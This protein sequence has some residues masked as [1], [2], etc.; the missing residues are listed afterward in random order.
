MKYIA[1]V[2]DYLY[3]LILPFFGVLL[4]IYYQ[5][6][7][8]DKRRVWFVLFI[9]TILLLF[10]TAVFQIYSSIMIFIQDYVDRNVLG[11]QIPVPAFASLQCIFFI[12]F[13]P[14]VKWLLNLLLKNGCDLSLLSRIPIGLSIGALGFLCFGGGEYFA[15]TTGA[16]GLIWIVLG[17]VFLGLGE[18]FL[19][20]P[21]LTAIATFSPKRWAGTFMGIFSI[22]L[23]SSSFLAGQLAN[24]LAGKW[25]IRTVS[26]TSILSLSYVRIALFLMITLAVSSLLFVCL[27]GWY[28]QQLTLIY[29]KNSSIK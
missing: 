9:T 11:W 4:W 15:L 20:P 26:A 8:V 29:D 27:Q 2:D 10:Y 21:I 28:K 12:I 3:A 16:C 14:I 13:A 22:S 25:V 18:V 24:A 17:N 1:S 23:A 7:Q 19:Y 5:L 6:N